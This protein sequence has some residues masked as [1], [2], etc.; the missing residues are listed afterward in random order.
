[1]P[2]RYLSSPG[3]QRLHRFRQVLRHIPCEASILSRTDGE[4]SPRVCGRLR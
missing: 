2:E 1:M 3:R 4:T